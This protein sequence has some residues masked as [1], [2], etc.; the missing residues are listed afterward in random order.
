M[1]MGVLLKFFYC[2]FRLFEFRK[3]VSDRNSCFKL[4][5][6]DY[7]VQIDKE[8][9]WS[10]CRVMEGHFRS[11]FVHYLPGLL[12]VESENAHF[13]VILP[14]K[15]ASEYYKPICLHMAGTGDHMYGMEP[16]LVE[17]SH[18]LLETFAKGVEQLFL[19]S[20]KKSEN[21]LIYADQAIKTANSEPDSNVLTLLVAY[22][23]R[24]RQLIAKPLLKEAGISSILLE[25]PFYGLRKPKDQVR[26]VLH[27]VSDIFV[28]GGCL[29]ME[30]LVLFHWCERQGLGP[31][32]VTGMS[33]GG[34][35]VEGSLHQPVFELIFELSSS[36]ILQIQREWHLWQRQIGPNL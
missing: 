26:S 19:F 23:W 31:L 10:D 9:E 24:R 14:K 25:N 36:K 11:P 8:E 35:G 5:D 12:P 13:Q 15:W 3:V 29:I 20:K 6:K 30:S 2:C 21:Q 33:M 4:V 34:H 16:S 7:P 27:N 17:K 28:M 1:K 32:G 18:W 22:F